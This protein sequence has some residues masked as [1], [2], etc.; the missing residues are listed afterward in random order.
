M[1]YQLKII[2]QKFKFHLTKNR[3][4]KPNRTNFYENQENQTILVLWIGGNPKEK[5]RKKAFTL[6]S[7][8][9]S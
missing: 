3:P 4:M 2:F 7:F 8:K 9:I 6:T 5:H 1:V